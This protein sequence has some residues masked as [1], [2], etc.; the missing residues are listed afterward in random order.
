[1]KIRLIAT[2]LLISSSLLLSACD[3]K[4]SADMSLNRTKVLDGKASIVMPDGFIK[5]PQNMLETK[6]PASQRPQEAWY[7]ESEGGKVSIAFSA[8]TNSVSESQVDK[9]AGAMKQQLKTFSPSVSE[10]T[11]NGKKMSRIE[12]VTPAA[13]G[14]IYNLMQLS[15]YN[16]KLLIST[17]NATEDLK[18]KYV[19]AGNDA[20]SSLSY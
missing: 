3:D 20:L 16:G 1:M 9:V 13:D 14:K 6:Y 4:N 2:S 12:M 5:M 15:S 11:V 19:Q 18:E 8:T 10:V 7:I 17:F